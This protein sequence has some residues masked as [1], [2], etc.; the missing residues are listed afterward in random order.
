M[1][2]FFGSGEG[3]RLRRV[4]SGAEECEWDDCDAVGPAIGESP[5]VDDDPVDQ[6]ITNLPVKPVE[7]FHVVVVDGVGQAA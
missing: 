1:G 2:R 7:T 6:S 5:G 3:G 4:R